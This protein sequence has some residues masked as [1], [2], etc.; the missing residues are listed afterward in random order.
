MTKV[1]D[2]I[3]SFGPELFNALV[4]G[5]HRRVAMD[6]PYRDAVKLRTRIHRLR[7]KMGEQDH[8]LYGLT[9]KAELRIEIPKGTPTKS[10]YRNIQTPLDP[11]AIVTLVIAPRD[12]DFAAAIRKAGVTVQ[13]LSTDDI[14]DTSLTPTDLETLLKDLK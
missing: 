2:P 10:K 11:G 14:S 3:D 1:K 8:Q 4:E 6:L 9:M 5:S 7:A 13:P 12:S